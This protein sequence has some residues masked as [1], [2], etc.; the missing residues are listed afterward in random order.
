MLPPGVRMTFPINFVEMPD[1][2]SSL[3]YFFVDEL[4]D[5]AQKY[6][7]VNPDLSEYL[8]ILKAKQEIQQYLHEA[9]QKAQKE[10]KKTKTAARGKRKA[11]AA[12]KVPD[13]I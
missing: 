6:S 3:H 11:A 4:E 7:T 8:K 2:W 10:S 12:S 1:T 9:Y 5:L 13:G